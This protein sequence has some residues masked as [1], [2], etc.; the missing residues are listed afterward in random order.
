MLCRALAVLALLATL[1]LAGCAQPQQ[2]LETEAYLLSAINELRAKQQCA[3]LTQDPALRRKAQGLMAVFENRGSSALSYPSYTQALER[4]RLRSASYAYSIV[5]T[6]LAGEQNLVFF[7]CN[8]LQD[9][10][11]PAQLRD[12]ALL[13]QRARRIGLAMGEVQG[14]LYWM[15]VVGVDT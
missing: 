15:A 4:Q 3:P 8:P 10:Q 2:D 14:T 11:L 5:G 9:T 1:L 6:R 13:D 12:R 7:L